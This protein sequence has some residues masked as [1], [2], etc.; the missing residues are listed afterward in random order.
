VK[1]A[2]LINIGRLFHK[3][4]SEMN[5]NYMKKGLVPKY[6]GKFTEAQSKEFIQQKTDPKA[7]AI[8]NEFAEMLKRNIYPHH[9]GS[10]RY[11]G[12]ILKW[13]KKIEEVVSAG[14]PNLVDENEE[15]IVNWLLVQSELTQDSKLV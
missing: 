15:R 6:M 4:M 12:K 5:M 9:M 3:W 10:S 11:V 1:S 2:M 7:L 8:S 14:N 13:K